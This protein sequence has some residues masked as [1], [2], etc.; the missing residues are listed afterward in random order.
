MVLATGT[1]ID[2]A[3]LAIVEPP[4]TAAASGLPSQ[5]LHDNV[6]WAETGVRAPGA[7]AVE[8]A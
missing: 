5:R 2:A 6:E 4:T 7:Q 1:V 8:R 3:A